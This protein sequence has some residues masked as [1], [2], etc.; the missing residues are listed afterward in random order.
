MKALHIFYQFGKEIVGG[1]EYHTYMLSR[2]LVKKGVEV[3][4][5][6][7]KSN[8]VVPNSPYGIYWRNNLNTEY[9][10]YDGLNI[11][12]CGTIPLPRL[13]GLALS[14]F[15]HNRMKIEQETGY[16]FLNM[17]FLRSGWYY[18][19]KFDDE[20][21][22]WTKKSADFFLAGEDISR[23]GIEAYSPKPVKGS[24]TVNN[25]KYRDFKLKPDEWTYFEWDLKHADHHL[26][27]IHLDKTWKPP[28]DNR[29]LGV[30]VRKIYYTDVRNEKELSLE[31]EYNN[32]I[33]N[34]NPINMFENY[35]QRALN[36]PIIYDYMSMTA[37]GPH[38]PKLFQ[39]LK[40]FARKSD[41]LMG[42]MVPFNTI[43]Y[44]TWAGKKTD[45]PT[46]LLPFFHIGDL[47][48][49]WRYFFNAFKE[50]DIIMA[51]SAYSKK[52]IF[53]RLGIKSEFVGSGV[54]FQELSSGDISGKRFR[55]KNGLENTHI[56]LFVA[57]KTFYKRYDM[58]IDAIEKLSEKRSDVKLVMIGPDEDKVPISSK[59]VQYL[60][61]V[62][63]KELLDAYDACD[64][65]VM[66][67]EYESFGIVFCEAWMREKPVIGNIK[68][69][70][71]SY[72]IENGIDGFLTGNSKELSEQI[73][74]L[75]NDQSL[76]KKMGARGRLKVINNFTWD[77]I[78]SKVKNIYE[79]LIEK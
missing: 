69:G 45:T 52:M 73:N 1:A 4:V 27:R 60:G 15:I 12:R 71:V 13:A 8:K 28:E 54:D 7:T 6:T 66:P 36:R 56:I 5:L 19:E 40:E 74:L 33:Q 21:V 38:S 32:L 34:L 35:L 22:R 59:N 24:I 31:N 62:D 68:C 67:S 46:V 30:M 57:R 2:E 49:Y 42:N 50:A 64:V 78:A 41:V 61:K 51:S 14:L 48:H 63:R 25:I 55:E 44:I 39:K 29:W 11:Y 72:L 76:S 75:L 47:N 9:E 37:K 18:L 3:D 20:L 26:C 70:P 53:D 79:S 23:V 43:N 58:A 17:S 77:I 16:K 10:S 65:F